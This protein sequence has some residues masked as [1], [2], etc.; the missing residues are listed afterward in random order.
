MSSTEIIVELHSWENLVM[1]PSRACT[2]VRP[3]ERATNMK[4]QTFQ[5]EWSIKL[6]VWSLNSMLWSIDSCKNRVSVDHYHMTVST[7]RGYVIEV[8]LKLSADKLLVFNWSLTQFQVAASV[9]ASTSVSFHLF[10]GTLTW[11]TP[12]SFSYNLLYLC[13][14]LKPVPLPIAILFL[15]RRSAE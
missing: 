5:Q 2:S 13:P 7:H 12:S 10:S 9:G 4:S 1:Y 6:H 11:Q 14:F 15:L 8:S 3:R